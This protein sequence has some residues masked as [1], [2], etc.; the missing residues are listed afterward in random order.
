MIY[1]IEEEE[2]PENDKNADTVK[3]KPVIQ[4]FQVPT[5]PKSPKTP[6]VANK[7]ITQ[8]FSS[9][10]KNLS[11]LNSSPNVSLAKFNSALSRFIVG[12]VTSRVLTNFQ[13]PS[14]V[15]RPSKTYT[16]KK[17]TL[18]LSS[19]SPLTKSSERKRR[20]LTI[21]QQTKVVP[22][23]FGSKTRLEDEKKKKLEPEKKEVRIKELQYEELQK[24]INEKFKKP[25]KP[26]TFMN[27]EEFF[28]IKDRDMAL[29]KICFQNWSGFEITS[30][31]RNLSPDKEKSL[32]F[33]LN[34]PD[35]N[36]WIKGWK[37]T[38]SPIPI[39]INFFFSSL[40]LSTGSRKGFSV[41]FYIELFGSL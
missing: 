12:K 25:P 5:S 6:S 40:F 4:I 16:T 36:L 35:L 8:T 10:N 23:A 3:A 33:T 18:P 37:G 15:A 19:A 39:L 9:A 32:V 41:T 17:F 30:D 29:K 24:L 2:T 20:E 34:H 22:K 13:K 21:F 1:N 31:M 26:T 27:E 7:K 38:V 14:I 28:H 11:H